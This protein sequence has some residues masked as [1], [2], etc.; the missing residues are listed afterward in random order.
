MRLTGIID[1]TMDNFLCIRGF[2]SMLELSSI[3]KADENIQRDLIE[4]HRGEMET[5]LP[6][7]KFTFS[8]RLSW[9]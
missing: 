9:V 3:S 2:A 8:L 7:G 6:D 4:E 1:Y 5:F